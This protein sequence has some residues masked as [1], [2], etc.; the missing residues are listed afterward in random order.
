MKKIS[1][2]AYPKKTSLNLAMKEQDGRDPKIQIGIFAGFLVF[3]AVFTK[4]AVIDK[5]SESFQAQSAYADL[6]N[7]IAQLKE[8]NSDY[9]S[10]RE[11]Y[12][13]YSNGYLNDD[14]KA[15]QDRMDVLAL[16]EKDVMQQASVQSVSV[17]GNT[18]T[19]TIN[20]ITLDVVS[21]IVATLEADE[22]TSYVTVSTAGT[23]ESSNSLVN[24]NMVIELVDG[25]D[26]P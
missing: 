9:D 18:V 17:S 26:Q 22:K 4:F 6:Q 21:Q 20:N 12:S 14:E 8:Y 7:Q 25:G 2:D 13:H 24:A 3:L 1:P 10:I 16:L 23:N 5:L 19:L 15:L 11:E